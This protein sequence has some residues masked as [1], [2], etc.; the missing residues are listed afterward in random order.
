MEINHFINTIIEN[1]IKS[2]KH[3][4]KYGYKTKDQ[5]NENTGTPIKF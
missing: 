4:P 5:K 1:D 3:E 2:K